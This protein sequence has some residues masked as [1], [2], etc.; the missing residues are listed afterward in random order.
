MSFL[1]G[2]S[3]SA[4][5][6]E[7]KCENDWT[8][9]E[10]EQATTLALKNRLLGRLKYRDRWNDIR[11]DLADPGNYVSGR[12]TDHYNRFR[13]D[14]ALADE[15]G[16]TALRLSFEWSRIQP[17]EGVVS[18]E[19]LAHYQDVIAELRARDITPV[20][21]LWHFTHPQWFIDEYGWAHEE[22]PRLFAEYVRTVADAFG[23]DIRFWLTVNEPSA[24]V[25]AAYVFDT[26]PPTDTSILNALTA[27]RHLVKAHRR[28]YEVLQARVSEATVGL[29]V[30]AGCFEP[31]TD[32]P[33]NRKLANL[34]RTVER[35]AFLD[36]CLPAVDVIGLNYYIHYKVDMLF[37]NLLG[38]SRPKSD[39]GWPLSP[40]GLYC[41]LMQMAQFDRPLLVTEHGLAD[42]AD[43]RRPWYL[44]ESIAYL[45]QARDE[46]V[47]VNGYFHWALTDNFEWEKGFWP[48]FGLVAV[49]YDDLSR[50]PRESAAVYADIIAQKDWEARW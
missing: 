38:E 3:L 9:W 34:L 13:E 1:W 35:D 6:T 28:A 40:A 50:E 22:A 43:D 8:R 17:E 24:W 45:A 44:S 37:R 20:V 41:L 23:D 14:I 19:A 7:G 4:H 11:D 10:H 42:A 30:A 48:R 39:L 5:Q 49:D 32:N 33:V 26:F 27:W 15:I 25:R 16:L 29:S 18:D 47:P 31:Y 12:A 36:A 46:G 21:T 2:A